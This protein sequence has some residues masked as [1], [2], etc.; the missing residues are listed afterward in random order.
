MQVSARSIPIH[1]S[2]SA[3]ATPAPRDRAAVV[4]RTG[5][6]ALL[7]VWWVVIMQAWLPTAGQ[8]DLSTALTSTDEGSVRNA[9][10]IGAVAV[11]GLLCLRG[12]VDLLFRP[13]NRLA[14]ALFAAYLGWSLTTFFWS[15]DVSLSL[16]RYGLLVLV[17][18]AAVGLGLGFYGRQPDG[19]KLLLKH[20][21]AAAVIAQAVLWVPLLQSGDVHLLDPTWAVK[22]LIGSPIGFPTVF[23]LVAA[24]YWLGRTTSFERALL[25][26]VF[27]IICGLTIF[28]Q[29]MRMVILSLVAVALIVTARRLGKH[30]RLAMLVAAV[31]LLGLVLLVEASVL[32]GDFTAPLRD[33]VWAFATL[34]ASPNDTG[35]LS[36]RVPL[37]DV[38][39][40]AYQQRA[41]IG[42]GFGAFW[43]SARISQVFEDAGWPA[44]TAHNGYLD[45][46]LA[47]GAIGLLLVVSAW[48]AATWTALRAVRARTHPEA[49]VVFIWLGLF[50][51][52]NT[53]GSILQW[54]FQFP[55]Y[56]SL[57]GLTTLYGL[58]AQTANNP[59][60]GQR[61]PLGTPT[62]LAWRRT[63]RSMPGRG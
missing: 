63:P 37:W 32:L 18:V 26:S 14:T 56:M 41:F 21:I 53:A 23:A 7:L 48:L 33:V 50:L 3:R 51:L 30:P 60:T 57:I 40:S 12:S 61:V 2:A 24:V 35:T 54:Y 16:R 22:D 52:F 59:D 34:D 20:V 29:K 25:L 45:E 42:H 38:L 39:W 9:L 28:A 13:G 27:A 46:A 58:Q 44:V 15:D 31:V 47:T 17:V 62:P 43:S 11:L 55:F 5:V 49:V 36:G 10:Q 4:R 8:T 6:S 1:S 19:L